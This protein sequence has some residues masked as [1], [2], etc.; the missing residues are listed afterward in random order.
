[1]K[2]TKLVSLLVFIVLVTGGCASSMSPNVYS[3]DQA[4]KVQTVHKGEVIMVREVQIE[5][6][7]SGAGAIAGGIMGFALGSTIGSGSG[8]TVARAAGTVGGA[9]AGA[10]IEEGA[11]RQMGLEITIELDNGEVV[12]IVQGAD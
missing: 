7:K 5:G 11:T 10:A 4:Q 1:M 2:T 9:A 8:R 12:S 3:R 6:T